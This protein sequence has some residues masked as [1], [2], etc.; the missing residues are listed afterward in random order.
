MYHVYWEWYSGLEGPGGE[1]LMSIVQLKAQFGKAWRYNSA[2]RTRC[3]DRK[4]LVRTM[5]EESRQSGPSIEA[6]IQ[7]VMT[8]GQAEIQFRRTSL[9]GN[10]GK[11]NL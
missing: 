5:E 11:E 9:R 2:L 7:E 4:P 3:C 8:P 6:V 10:C 1:T